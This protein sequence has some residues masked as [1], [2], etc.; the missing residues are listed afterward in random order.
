MSFE[1]GW[2]VGFELQNSLPDVASVAL[3]DVSS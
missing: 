3:V 2:L 1:V